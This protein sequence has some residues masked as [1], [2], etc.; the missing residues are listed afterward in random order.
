MDIPSS[1]QTFDIERQILKQAVFELSSERNLFNHSVAIFKKLRYNKI[2][3]KG[4]GGSLDKI[5]FFWDT[6]IP[7]QEEIDIFSN[8][9]ELRSWLFCN[10]DSG[11]L[12][13]NIAM[14]E[15]K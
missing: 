12:Y 11:A 7:E 4:R 3:G 9:D 13:T 6:N 8:I 1:Y 15:E 2:R 5:E 14:I 10:A